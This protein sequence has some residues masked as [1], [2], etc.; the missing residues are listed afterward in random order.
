MSGK[1]TENP[2]V[3]GAAPGSFTRV[4]RPLV[5][6]STS[7]YRRE[8]LQRLQLRFTAVAPATD[9][10]PHRGETPRDTALRLACDKARSVVAQFPDA[11]IVGSDQVADCAG[12]L[13][14]KPGTA[15]RARELLLRLSGKT[16][17][18][19]TALALLDARSGHIQSAVVDVRS[20]FRPLTPDEIDA[21]LA[22]EAALDCAGA[23][24]VES[25]GIALFSSVESDDPTALIG[26]P[27]IRLT[28]ML[29]RV[30]IRPL[31]RAT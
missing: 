16:V 31:A 10:T 21:Y 6:A 25:L 23:V 22:R 9:E 11:F 24:K 15:E 29:Q 2:Q 5:L 14:G 17:V 4:G 30:G 18:F 7:R 20:T 28:D 3:G 13:V 26:L 12:E 27:L 19:H 1:T 8:L